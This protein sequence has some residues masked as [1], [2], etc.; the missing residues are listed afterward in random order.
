[1][2]YPAYHQGHRGREVELEDEMY[3]QED[4]IDYYAPQE[5]VYAYSHPTNMHKQAQPRPAYNN[6]PVAS[7]RQPK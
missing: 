6:V 4:Y 1:M 7:H 2:Q 5:D 3:G